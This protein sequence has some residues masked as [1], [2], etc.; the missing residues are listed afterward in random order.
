[1]AMQVGAVS[2]TISVDAAAPLLQTDRAEVRQE[3]GTQALRDLPVPPGRN[4]QGLFRTVPG[5]TPPNNAHS[6]PSNPSRS[7]Q[8]NVNGASSSSNDV[9]IDGASQFNVW[10][11]H[12]TAYVPALESIETVNVVTN[13]FDAEQGLAGGSAVNVQIKS[14]TN[15]LHGSAFWYHNNNNTKAKPFFLPQGQ[16]N[17]KLVYNQFGGTVDGPLVKNRLFY[18][19]SFEGTRDR[20]FA[21]RFT[22]VPTAATRQ[23]N[24]SESPASVRRRSLSMRWLAVS[25]PCPNTGAT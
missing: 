8:Y 18:F 14:G 20:Q 1:M 4:Y 17:P 11:P 21:S 13:N 25:M 5:F 7:L 2:E 24:F 3:I 10:L 15:E 16:D 6:V 23:G 22:T 12:V 9:R 19:A